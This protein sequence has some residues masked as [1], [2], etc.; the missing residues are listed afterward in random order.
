MGKITG[1]EAVEEIPSEVLLTYGAVQELVGEGRDVNDISVSAITERAGIGKGTI[2]DYFDSREEIVACAFLFYVR[3]TAER[4]TAMAREY[5]RFSDAVH[6][7][8]DQ[9]DRNSE[10]KT[11]FVR[12]IHGATDNSKYSPII[13]EKLN[14]TETGRKL[15]D[16]LFGEI[17]RMG[18]ESGEI[19]RN[20]PTEYVLYAIFC[21]VMTYMMCIATKESF[22]IDN[23]KMR[24]LVIAGLL[25]ELKNEI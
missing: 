19:D 18:M 1:L 13:R 9:L 21:K 14:R 4:M 17:I 2:Y 6:A 11:C 22:G 7:L 3:Q 25:K 8:F 20:L 5:D 23:R 12:F 15:P 24:E 10:Q 16:R